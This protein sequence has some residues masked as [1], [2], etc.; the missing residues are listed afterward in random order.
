MK[1]EFDLKLNRWGPYNKEYLGV[2]H[3]ANEELGSTFQVELFPGLFR[4]KIL[5]SHSS[6]DDGLKMW[7]A[8]PQLTRFT[9][10][11][12]LEWKDRLYCDVDFAVVDD[13]KCDI[14]CTFVNNTELNQSVNMNLCASLQYPTLKK[15]GIIDGYRIPFEAVLP[16]GCVIVDALDYAEIKCCEVLASDGRYLGE[17]YLFGATGKTTV[18]SGRYFNDGS[19]FVRYEATIDSKGFLLR[20]AAS[21]DTALDF[22]VGDEKK[23]VAV[24]GS[25]ELTSIWIDLEVSKGSSIEVRPSCPVN[26]DCL[27]FGEAAGKTEFRALEVSTE[28]ER[29]VYEN[30]IVLRYPLVDSVYTVEWHEP[31]QFVRRY[32]YNDIGKGLAAAIHNH[33]STELNGNG[34]LSVFENLLSEPFYLSPNESKSLH[35]T[36]SSGEC[37]GV[38]DEDSDYEVKSNPDG[39][40][41][42]FSQNMMAYNTFLNVV[43]PIYTRRGYIRHNTPGRNWDSLYSW[44][45]GFIGM[46][47]AT[48]D[49]ARGFDCLNTY[50]TPVGDVH[51]PYIFHG[52]VVPTQIFLYQYLF[53]KYPDERNRLKEIYPMIRQMFDFYANMDQRD[54]QLASKFLKTWNIFYNSGGWDDYPPQKYVHMMSNSG[55]E[56]ISRKNT[57]P[58]ITT[59]ITVLIAKILMNISSEMGIDDKELYERIIAKYS[60]PILKHAWNDDTGYFSYVVHDENG[61]PKEFLKAPDGSDYNQGFDGIYPYIA[62]ITDEYQN[63][64]ILDNIKNGLMTPIG[65]SVVDTRASYFSRSGYWNG[66]VW[67]PHQWILWT[68][69]L[70]H[71]EGE[72]AFEIAKT[73]LD[74]WKKETEASYCCFEHFMIESGRGC[75][76]HQFSGLSTPVLMFFESYYTPSTVTVGFETVV[77]EK[78]WNESFTSLSMK[79]FSRGNKPVAIVCMSGG[80]DYSFKINSESVNARRI[81][82]GAYEIELPR[83]H[84]TVEIFVKD[85]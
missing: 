13:K 51:S 62:N 31:M 55:S 68:S 46:G 24:P 39:E 30:R 65:V 78:E 26:I 20:C 12:E 82:D 80:K 18:L 66:S 9:Y 32:R 37:V 7:K 35:F 40:T 75:G 79:C 57:A 28:A 4:R 11:Y 19:H 47:L 44:D 84:A 16:D 53:N 49:F 67:F 27:V 71:G 1:K 22:T 59:A 36:V 81:T 74:L 6:S 60:E 45:S 5:I 48:A 77:C 58:V 70:D 64:R 2:S 76:F 50:L 33:G 72:L 8:N 63:S 10:R 61:D 52:S 21:K 17:D 25:D 69:L 38:G 54:D 29:S 14:T 85:N 3:I 15:G 23:S 56:E 83:G 41:Y 43:Y 34:Y 73:A 42:V